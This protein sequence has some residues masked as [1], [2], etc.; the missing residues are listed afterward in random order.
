MVPVPVRIND[1]IRFEF[2][3]VENR[4]AE[5]YGCSV[6][7]QYADS[8]IEPQNKRSVAKIVNPDISSRS[9]WNEHE[10]EK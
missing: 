4:V 5:P 10:H 8:V 7:R 6:I 1:N 2:S 9:T 3:D